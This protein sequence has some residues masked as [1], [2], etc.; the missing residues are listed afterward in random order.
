[1]LLHTCVGQ[2][3]PADYARASATER[4]PAITLMRVSDITGL[5]LHGSARLWSWPLIEYHSQC[6]IKGLEIRKVMA[7]HPRLLCLA[8]R[9]GVML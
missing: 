8:N 2:L 4:C 5:S 9:L 3:V 6:L 1:M 7:E